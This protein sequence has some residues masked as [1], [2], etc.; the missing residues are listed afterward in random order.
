MYWYLTRI[1][2]VTSGIYN[3][4]GLRHHHVTE[5]PVLPEGGVQREWGPA[6][7]EGWGN[8]THFAQHHP[9]HLTQGWAQNTGWCLT[10]VCLIVKRERK[11]ENKSWKSAI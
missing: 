4:Q 7:A 11:E 3:W 1:W 2:P 5:L 9:W 10:A 6:V 8:F